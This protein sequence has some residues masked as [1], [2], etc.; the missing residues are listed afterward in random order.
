MLAWY[1]SRL[2]LVQLENGFMKRIFNGLLIILMLGIA[3]GDVGRQDKKKYQVINDFEI[4]VVPI[5]VSAKDSMKIITVL[6]IPYSSL[7]FVKDSSGFKA[8]Y[9]ATI[10][11][12][13]KDHHQYERLIWQ[14]SIWVEDYLQTISIKSHVSHGKQI[15]VPLDELTIVAEITDLETHK[16]G[17]RSETFS[18]SLNSELPQLLE[19][20]I[21]V[22]K[23]GDWGFG[24]NLF[25]LISTNYSDY[26]ESLFVYISG[27]INPIPYELNIS[28]EYN[29]ETIWEDHKTEENNND[30]FHYTIQIPADSLFGVYM[31]LVSEIHQGNNQDE[32][33]TD[34]RLKQKGISRFVEDI[35]SALEQMRYILS[36]EEKQRLKK[37]SNRDK[38]KLFFEFWID[39][40]PTPMTSFNELMEE[41]YRRVSFSN[42]H[43]SN[44]Q[45]GWRSDMGM[46]YILMGPPDDL[47]RINMPNSRNSYEVWYYHRINERFTFVD[48]NGFGDFRLNEPF[49][50][51]PT[52]G[53]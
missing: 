1:G 36:N 49:L 41:Y 35:D 27:Y 12:Q 20:V 19:P 51:Y 22:S 16:N 26:P 44:F 4:K 9:E 50:G 38:E 5:A 43:F 32:K 18:Y 34:V 28:L 6:E 10:A 17:Y 37:I 29:E 23:K 14:E 33:I 48:T 25:P 31:S 40:D 47:E 7:Q 30:W 45:P 42:E 53:W 24:P 52:S 15:V 11:V 21:L 8:E 13:G 46:I 2:G 39:R 3:V